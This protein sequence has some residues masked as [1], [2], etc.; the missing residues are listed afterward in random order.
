MNNGLIQT[1]HATL[2]NAVSATTNQ[3]YFIYVP[4]RLNILKRTTLVFTLNNT[5]NENTLDFKESNKIYGLTAQVNVPEKHLSDLQQ[6]S[7]YIR[8]ALYRLERSAPDINYVSLLSDDL[9]FDEEL[10]VY[11]YTLSF[12]IN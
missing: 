2:K 5:G 3:V 8:T 9:Q 10:E 12:Q 7:I 11:V 1:I 6:L 4:D